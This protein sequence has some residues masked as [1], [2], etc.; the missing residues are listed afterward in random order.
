MTRSLRFSSWIAV[1]LGLLT[2]LTTG[3]TGTNYAWTVRT[4]SSQIAVTSDHVNLAQEPIAVLIALAPPGLR[5]NEAGLADYLVSIIKKVAPSWNILDVQQAVSIINEHGLAGDYVR[6]RTDA[7]QSHILNRD[8]LEK[9]GTAIGARFVFQPRLAY[10]SQEFEDRLAFPGFNLRL[11]Q[12]RH[13]VLRVSLT[14]WD[15]SNGALLWNSSAEANLQSEAVSQDPVFF[16]DAAR[17]ALACMMSDLLNRRNNSKYTPVNVF[18]DQLMRESVPLEANG[19]KS[20][21]EQVDVQKMEQE[22]K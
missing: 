11:M 9:L 22:Q 16:E 14:L 6:S 15:T 18:I 5:G 12:T 20:E 21:P 2:L 1:G 17:V 3:C 7:E 8:I 10:F 13:S 4:T 19:A